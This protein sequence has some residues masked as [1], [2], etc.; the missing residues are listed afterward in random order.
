[1]GYTHYW[2]R[3]REIKPDTYKKIVSDFKTVMP[4]FKWLG[5]PLAGPLGKGKPIITEN[6]VRFNGLEACGH[7]H[8]DLGITWPAATVKNGA[9]PSTELAVVG[10]WFAGAEL[11]QRTCDGDCSHETF[12]FP[13]SLPSSER[14]L[15]RISYYEANGTPVYRDSKEIGR[16]FQFCKTAYKPYDLA[17]TV[18]LVIAK[19]YLGERLLVSSDGEIQHWTEAVGIC[20]RAFGYGDDFKLEDEPA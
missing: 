17:V 13:R 1:M 6:D 14:P 12:S 15:G 9:A 4:G 10:S 11:N 2:S 18:F 20:N 7:G 19:H 3:E 8:R 5:I 16:F